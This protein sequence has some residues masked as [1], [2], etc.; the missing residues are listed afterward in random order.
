MYHVIDY[1]DGNLNWKLPLN[2]EKVWRRMIMILYQEITET[3]RILKFSE[4][5]LK[6]VHILTKCC[7]LKFLQSTRNRKR[8]DVPFTKSKENNPNEKMKM[9]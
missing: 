2:T 1:S 7:I 6:R 4:I 5:C 3:P 8:K 9:Q